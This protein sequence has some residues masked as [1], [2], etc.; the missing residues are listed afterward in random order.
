[1]GTPST[2]GNVAWYAP[3]GK[4]GGAGN[5]VFAGHVNNALTTHGVFEHLDQVKKGDYVTVEGD[6]GKT[7]VYRVESTSTSPM[8]DAPAPAIFA[9]TG[10][11]KLVLITCAGDWIQSEREFS[12]R[13]IVVAVPA[14]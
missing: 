5:A 3:G 13:L 7:I 4:P 14:Y 8:S 2:F 10:P 12:E 11:H 9:T 1:M 6:G